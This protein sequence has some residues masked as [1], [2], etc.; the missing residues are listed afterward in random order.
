M[1]DGLLN[2]LWPVLRLKPLIVG[3]LTRLQSRAVEQA[4]IERRGLE[5]LT[6]KIN[7]IS[8]TRDIYPEAIK[9]GEHILQSIG[10][11]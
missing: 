3:G 2:G 6:N 10:F 9:Y 1:Q 5:N 8:K 7:S 4:I 11:K